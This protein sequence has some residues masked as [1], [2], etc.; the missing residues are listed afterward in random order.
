MLNCGPHD[1]PVLA[2]AKLL[3]PLG[4]PAANSTKYFATGELLVLLE[5]RAWLA[6]VTRALAEHW[7]KKNPQRGHSSAITQREQIPS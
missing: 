1:I 4:E 2:A 7:K 5:D 6:K 3:R